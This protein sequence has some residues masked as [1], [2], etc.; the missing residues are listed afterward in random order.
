MINANVLLK[1]R[2]DKH[3]NVFWQYDGR[4]WLENNITKAFINTIDSLEANS[5]RKL[6]REL[7]G[8]VLPKADL[9][10]EYYL[11]TS[12]DTDLLNRISDSNKVLFAFSPT[13]KSWGTIGI[14]AGDIKTIEK[15]I[16]RSVREYY[17]M[18]SDESIRIKVAE[19]LKETIETINNRGGSIPD[20]WILVFGNGEPLYC[21]AMENKLHDLDPF[22]LRNHCQKALKVSENRIQYCKYSTL[23]EAFSS[24]KGF[25]VEDFLRYMYYLN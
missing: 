19:Q 24:M 14:D 20:A 17:P 11:Q 13:G 6:F 18:D 4:P 21:V 16:E 3:L 7:F 2:T 1:H 25:L 22:Q 12:P 10:F 9:S 5:K 23:L 8:F 15:Y